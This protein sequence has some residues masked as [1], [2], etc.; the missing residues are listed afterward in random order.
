M[1]HKLPGEVLAAKFKGSCCLCGGK[2]TPGDRIH[3]HQRQTEHFAC[4]E[5]AAAAVEGLGE[6]VT[7]TTEER[8]VLGVPRRT[9]HL[10][11][12]IVVV[13]LVSRGR[14]YRE[15]GLSFGLSK[16]NGWLYTTLARPATVEEIA[17]LEA[18]EA[19][20]AEQARRRAETRAAWRELRALVQ[21]GD[22]PE[23]AEPQ[24]R[25]WPARE[26]RRY[27]DDFVI[28][29]EAGGVLW[30]ATYNG[31]DG[32]CWAWSNWGSEIAWRIPLTDEARALLVR[33]GA[34]P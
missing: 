22:K 25:E 13:P 10:E 32:D 20:A 1:T 26:K 24:G 12:S 15:D 19:A 23:K 30:H 16:D 21:Q 2:V 28:I 8:P 6:L 18:E 29:D 31:R 11:G 5:K 14:Y 34:L 9:R 3:Y 27:D 7:L 17:A 4:A 33:V